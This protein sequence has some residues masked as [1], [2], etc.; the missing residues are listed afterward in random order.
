[1]K[2]KMKRRMLAIV[3]C[4]V[5]VLSNSSFIF[6]SS[7]SGTPAVEAASTEGTTSQTETDTQ[8]TET[9]PQTL[10]VSESTPAPTDEPAAPT[11]VDATPTPT[12]TPEV[13]TTP[14]PTGTPT[15]EATPTPTD[16][17]ETTTTPEPTDTPETTTTPQPTDAPETTTTP[18]PTDTPETTT[19]PEPTDTPEATPTQGPENG[20]SDTVQ[21]TET[22]TPT[23][24]TDGADQINPLPFQSTY[25][26]D[27]IEIRVSAEAG[28]VP[29]G[30]VLS[31][32]P[33]VKTEVTA[34]MTEEE[35]AEAEAINNQYD[36]TEKKLNE[37]S[38]KNETTME[39]FLAYDISFIVNGEEVEPDGDVKVVMDFKK[40]AIPEGV[41][42]DADVTVK[43]LKEDETAEDGIVVENMV[44]KADVQ[45]TEK[46]EVE[47]VEF[48]ANSFSIFSLSWSNTKTLNVQ[49]VNAKGDSIGQ[50]GSYEFKNVSNSRIGVDEIAETI[51][52]ECE[53]NE[54]F[55]RAVYVE[56]NA[57]FSFNAQ[58]VY[59]I[60]YDSAG[61]KYCQQEKY[62]TNEGWDSIGKGTIYFVFGDDPALETTPVN[63]VST[64][65]TI[66]INLFDY[67]VGSDGNEE[68]NW[69]NSVGI[70]NGHVLKF[71]DEKGKNN[72]NI[73][74]NQKESS[75]YINSGMVN[76]VLTDGF[77]TLQN[78]DGGDGSSLDYL[79]NDEQ[80][81]NVKTTYSG[82]DYLFK[83][84]NEGYHVF[85]S[86]E[87]Y[88]Y[89]PYSDGMFSSDFSVVNINGQDSVGF[90]PFSQPSY[91]TLTNIKNSSEDA[92]LG[93]TGVNH[94]YGMTIE[95]TFI[96]PKGGQ[97]TTTNGNTQKMIFEFSGDDDVW[98]FI[99]DVLVLDLGGIH[100]KVSGTINFATGEVTRTDINGGT[101]SGTTIRNAFSEANVDG[102][103]KEGTNTFSD[104]STHTIKFFYLERGNV[105]S[106][107][108]IKFNFPTIP[109][110]SVTIAKE[111][112]DEDG[113]GIDYADDI[114]FK[115]NIKVGNENYKN[116]QY[117]LWENGKQVLDEQGNP[118][119]G[120]TDDEGNFTL[121]HSQMAVFSELDATTQY[122][123]TELGAY[124][125]GYSVTVDDTKCTINQD[126]SG[127]E[128]IYSATTGDRSVG[129]DAS[130]VFKNAISSRTTLNIKKELAVGEQTTEDVFQIQ[131]KIQ[132]ELYRGTYSIGNQSGYMAQDGIINLKVGEIASI[133]GLPYGASFEVEEVLDGSY[134]PTY[135]I[136]GNGIYDEKV[137]TDS[138]DLNTVTGKI[139]GEGGTV[140]VINSK[141]V[142]S[143]GT[144]KVTVT[145]TWDEEEKY[146]DLIP[147]SIK[148]TLYEDTNHN[149]QYDEGEPAVIKD[150]DGNAISA[151]ATLSK[152]N[153]THTWSNLPA[154][155]DFVITEKYPEGFEWKT[156]EYNNEL[157]N[158]IGLGK[159]PSCKNKN[160]NIGKNNM[161]LVK[162]TS[163]DGYF[164]WSVYDL[165]LSQEEITEIAKEIMEIGL[166]GD[167]NLTTT[168]LEYHYGNADDSYGIKITENP[169]GWNLAFDATSVWAMFW[170]F[171]Y[172]RTENI[173]LVN[174]IDSDLK[175]EVKVNKVWKGNNQRDNVTV[176][177]IP[178]VGGQ[179]LTAQQIGWSG[180]ISVK[181]DENCEWKHTYRNLPYYYYDAT[182]ETYKKIIYTVTETG[183][184][185]DYFLMKPGEV[186]GDYIFEVQT[187]GE[188]D[189]TIINTRVDRWAIYKVSST[190]D[191][192]PLADAEFTL[193][194]TGEL[195]P[196][197]KGESNSWGAVVWYTMSGTPVLYLDDGVYKLEE[198]KAPS[199]YQKSDEIW[200]ITIEK[201]T[202]ISITRGDGLEVEPM[203][204]KTREAEMII[205]YA[206]TNTPLYDLPSA[207]SSGIFGYTMGGTLLLMAG[208]LI[209]YKMKRKEV[210][211]S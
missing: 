178:T 167:G 211:E 21:P 103:L 11:S 48:T 59:G 8:V 196:Q 204:S 17:P 151:E 125:N 37:D 191:A 109:K 92:V 58:Q 97:I 96:Q 197:Y 41:S 64:K 52:E 129:N 66:S 90:Y 6:A 76:R 15:P 91:D 42:E 192:L 20:T 104:Y 32:T 203:T 74:I 22:P 102:D 153:W 69:S 162:K 185:D 79:F 158:L 27:T 94:Y 110:D 113:R 38:E 145:K 179:E 173:S 72:Q 89:L 14:E 180:E 193:T 88:A 112:T 132:G 133:S 176:K 19:T 26:D 124:L 80:A 154:D 183:M 13:T 134:L 142:I 100:G 195:K 81:S 30:A 201:S 61:F 106:N 83:L 84:D 5:I 50:N 138:N 200:T 186:V 161:L 175:T 75:G 140:T 143:D 65:D 174:Q 54:K 4:M 93:Y 67:Q 121:K 188:N 25:G 127:E 117:A 12:D 116:Q 34:D 202:L 77:P 146:S 150:A 189:F 166:G 55:N 56:E 44:E 86:D 155:T 70:N 47:K 87:N 31:V 2:S 210:Q 123:V 101:A 28:I 168:N 18:Q 73:N 181:L 39:G 122:N 51:Q 149:Q 156:T 111:V 187:N 98:V 63:T 157:T 40:V 163:N 135:T 68:A 33:I 119:T 147:D 152:D 82:L 169:D 114:D 160:H 78:R 170:K 182:T 120:N 60:Y 165:K 148:V 115:F 208:T 126:T 46:A 108:M 159:V 190:D 130:V 62:E 29:E 10:A 9:T 128:T 49:V 1:M 172:D 206:F 16:T 171:Q 136:A 139:T 35:K 144:T 95:T 177:L 194:K 164:L 184:N 199:G 105:D 53:V 118:V 131:V 207:G 36:L 198:T 209:L 107:C 43:H 71:V 85:N 141:V 7:E 3:L 137:P 57:E 45:T 205:R 24:A 23:E 99:D